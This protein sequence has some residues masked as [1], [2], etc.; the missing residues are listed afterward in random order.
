V[1]SFGVIHHTPNPN[2]AIEQIQRYMDLS[3]ELRMMLYAKNS[4]KNIMI[5][6]GFDQPEAQSGCPIAYTFTPQQVRDLLDGFQILEIR[7]D[8]IFPFVIEKYVKYEY[9]IA[10]WFSAMPK[11]MFAALEK[12]LGWHMLITARIA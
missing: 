4:W 3:S 2:R 5:D 7:Q 11:V 6:A 10:P 8:H 1:Y 9:E 12:S